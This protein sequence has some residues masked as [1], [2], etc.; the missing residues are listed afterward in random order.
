M[1][2]RHSTLFLKEKGIDFF[3][4][5]DI[6]IQLDHY[7]PERLT[8]GEL[9]DRFL[10][11]DDRLTPFLT[12]LPQL[13]DFEEDGR[14]MRLFIL[15]EPLSAEVLREWNMEY[16][17]ASAVT[18]EQHRPVAESVFFTSAVI[19][20]WIFSSFV[21]RKSRKGLLFLAVLFAADDGTSEPKNPL[22]SSRSGRL[23]AGPPQPAP[24]KRNSFS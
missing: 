9:K 4:A 6:E 10:P 2:K 8:I 20:T 12:R 17:D 1:P 19:L 11:D 22:L 18:V 21:Q 23:A 13:F 3:S 24:G 15:K 14:P 16:P 5:A 7:N